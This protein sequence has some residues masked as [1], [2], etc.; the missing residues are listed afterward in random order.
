MRS[1]ALS[2]KNIKIDI[3]LIFILNGQLKLADECS[4]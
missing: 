1:R 4:D 3:Y 2:D